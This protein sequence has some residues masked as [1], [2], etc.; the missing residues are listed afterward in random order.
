MI[1]L[2][3]DVD[4]DKVSSQSASPRDLYKITLLIKVR[5]NSADEGGKWESYG[6]AKQSSCGLHFSHFPLFFHNVASSLPIIIPRVGEQV[7]NS[8]FF[9]VVYISSKIL[10]LTA[11]SRDL[12]QTEKILLLLQ[13]KQL[14]KWQLFSLKITTQ[15]RDQAVIQR[16]HVFQ[17]C[18]QISEKKWYSL[19]L[20][21]PTKSQPYLDVY[22]SWALLSSSAA[23]SKSP[24][25][26]RVPMLIFFI[27]TA[28]LMW[29]H[30]LIEI[31]WSN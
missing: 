6:I 29:V 21:F 31:I 4:T 5:N 12:S 8:N 30:T 23:V 17:V 11:G 16:I 27:A 10:Q 22:I 9:Y 20:V 1:A 14:P 24:L 19:S 7:L 15:S 26:C 3:G 25:D 18:I 13:T 28:L 2:I